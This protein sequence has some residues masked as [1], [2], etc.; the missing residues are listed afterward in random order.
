MKK[1]LLISTAII[2]LVSGCANMSKEQQA[3]LGAGLGAALGAGIGKAVGGTNGVAIGAG[4]GAVVGG[5]AGY[6]LASDP[7]TQTVT[8]Q[9]NVW[10]QD[11][12]AKSQIIKASN[13]IENGQEV[14]K[15]E[16]SKTIVADDQMVFKKHL[17]TKAKSRLIESQNKLIPLGGDVVVICPASATKTVIDE[18]TNTGV[19]VNQDN[20]LRT[21]YVI[22][23]TKSK[24]DVQT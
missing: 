11:T 6:A 15:I 3:A 2:F 19:T 10:Q 23:L 1:T 8:Q 13:V 5:A 17:S 7:Y 14:Q 9:A 16:T 18:I 12:G 24:N 4:L 20:S 22:V 21:G